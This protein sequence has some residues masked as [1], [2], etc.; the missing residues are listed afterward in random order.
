MVTSEV[1]MP[2]RATLEVRTHN[3]DNELSS[4]SASGFTRR[5]H[6]P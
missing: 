1:V 2:N 3:L 5:K 4:A 6:K